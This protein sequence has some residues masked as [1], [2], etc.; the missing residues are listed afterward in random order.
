M[1]NIQ[2]EYPTEYTSAN[3]LSEVILDY[4][5]PL[6]NAA[7]GN[8]GEVKAISMSIIFWNA[9]LFPKAKALETI[10]PALNEMV[11]GDQLLKEE[12]YSIFKMMYNRKQS[13]FSKDIRSVVDYSLEE[14]KQGFHLQVA[15][16][17]I[18]T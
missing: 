6:I 3:K 14:N 11:K 15:S 13:L 12:F 5:E 18:K 1:R 10:E 17:P 16:T 2:T 9:S 7:G 8:E 4:A